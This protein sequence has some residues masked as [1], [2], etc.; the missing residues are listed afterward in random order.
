MAWRSDLALSC[1]IMALKESDSQVFDLVEELL[2]TI[3]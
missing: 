1:F 3:Y 2:A